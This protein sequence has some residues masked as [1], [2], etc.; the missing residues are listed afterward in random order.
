MSRIVHLQDTISQ[1][2]W[3]EKRAEIEKTLCWTWKE[4]EN[5]FKFLL[6][7]F[8]L[9]DWVTWL[10]PAEIIFHLRGFYI[11]FFI[12]ICIYITPKPVGFPFQFHLFGT[13]CPN[14]GWFLLKDPY[15]VKQFEVHT[16]LLGLPSRWILPAEYFKL[17]KFWMQQ[18]KWKSTQTAAFC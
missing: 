14:N 17:N 9:L 4:Q 7:I 3:G 15:C 2:L 13:T 6:L 12:Y 1:Q 8:N 10:L 16:A 5:E 11:F 18:N